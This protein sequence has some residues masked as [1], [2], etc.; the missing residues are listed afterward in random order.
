MVSSNTAAAGL[1]STRRSNAFS[2]RRK[3]SVPIWDDRF[4]LELVSPAGATAELLLPVPDPGTPATV[5][6][7][8]APLPANGSPVTLVSAGTDRVHLRAAPGSHRIELVAAPIA[9]K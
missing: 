5:L 8:G 9:A 6:L 2:R 7:N 1:T 4:T 3:T